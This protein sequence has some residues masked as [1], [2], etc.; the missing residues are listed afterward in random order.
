MLV[1]SSAAGNKRS[2]SGPASSASAKRKKPKDM[3]R[4]PLS[5]YNMYFQ[6]ER[7]RTIEKYERGEKQDDFDLPEGKDPSEALFQALQFAYLAV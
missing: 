4:R 6:E 1:E 7:K 5:A 3:P 2:R